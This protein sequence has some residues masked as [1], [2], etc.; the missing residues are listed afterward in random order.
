[1]PLLLVQHLH[2]LQGSRACSRGGVKSIAAEAVVVLQ[3]LQ[4]IS[5]RVAIS[6]LALFRLPLLHLWRWIHQV[7]ATRN[8]TSI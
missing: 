3:A 2:S 7:T 8:S 6:P 4:E 5:S 1:M